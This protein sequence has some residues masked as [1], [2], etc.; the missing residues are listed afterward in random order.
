MS[1]KSTY[2]IGIAR[3]AKRA[4]KSYSS[5]REKRREKLLREFWNTT[6]KKY[7][8]ISFEFSRLFHGPQFPDKAFI[9]LDSLRDWYRAILVCWLLDVFRPDD[10]WKGK[11][12]SQEHE[13]ALCEIQ[14]ESRNTGVR[15]IQRLVFRDND[16]VP[17][18]F[19]ISDYSHLS[20]WC[21]FMFEL[22]SDD[23][24]HVDQ[25][26]HVLTFRF[27]KGIKYRLEEE[28]KENANKHKQWAVDMTHAFMTAISKG[29]PRRVEPDDDWLLVIWSSLAN[30][31]QSVREVAVSLFVEAISQPKEPDKRMLG[32]MISSTWK[33]MRSLGRVC[34]AQPKVTSIA[35]A[36]KHLDTV[37]LWCHRQAAREESSTNRETYR[38]REAGFRGRK[39]RAKTNLLTTQVFPIHFEDFGG[40]QFERLVFAYHL[41]HEQWRSLE[42]YGQSGSDLGRDIWG[43][44]LN[45]RGKRETVCIQCANHKT[46]SSSKAT[47]AIDKVLTS[48]TGKP[49][50]FKFVVGCPLSASKRE[51]IRAHANSKGIG[52]CEIWSGEEF[53]E[54][55]RSEC[56]SLLQR[57]AG[58]EA[59]PDSP[60]DLRK[61]V[62][63]TK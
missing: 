30:R 44:R 53:E 58:G 38:D 31:K 45:H 14:L 5:S 61:F 35:E 43:V 28:R 49:D 36:R 60:N 63:T 9:T 55:L 16:D 2:N 4:M 8:S 7:R 24:Q 19:V 17:R 56:E 27:D 48:L 41:R 40:K 34:C 11:V 26:R 25:E 29:K 51:K 62:E 22:L 1:A 23:E 59:F 46:V 12:P 3:T 42:W 47:Q 33:A 15:R 20:S 32:D 10:F 39:T 6:P 18:Q 50:V 37:K 54:R 57:F 52:S 21:D 13:L